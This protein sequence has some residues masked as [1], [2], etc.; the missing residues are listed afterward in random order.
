MRRRAARVASIALLA[1]L[2]V[3]GMA[4]ADG[5]FTLTGS[6]TTGRSY[7]QT[8]TSLSDCK[9]LVTGGTSGFGFLSSAELYDPA[10]GVFTATGSMIT[11][12]TEQTATLLP[13]GKVLVTGGFDG[14]GY[15]S[16]AELYDPASGAF[17][18]TGS[19]TT[20]RQ[21]QTATLLPGGKVLITGGYDA[22]GYLSSA[23]LYDPASGTFAATGSMSA[24]RAAQ[25]AT[26]LPSGKVLISGG[27]NGTG[28]L[29]SAELYDPASGTFTATGSMTS[30]RYAHSATLLPGG[31]VLV[32]GGGDNSGY[33]SSAELYD[34]ASGT[35]TAT[36]SMATRRLSPTATLLPDGKVLVTG[37]FDGGGVLSSADLYDPAA[38]TFTATGS[39]TTS[40]YRQSATLLPGGKVLITGGSDGSGV[41]SSAE[42]FTRPPPAAPVLSG[43]PASRTKST[44]AS[45]GFSGKSGASFTCSVDGGAYG[46]CGDSP[47]SLTGLA[48]GAHS[49]SVKQTDL[50]GNTSAAATASW[51]VDLTAPAAPVLSGVPSSPTS[52]TGASVS[53]TG[54]VGAT[55]QCSVDA[56]NYS[57]CTSP[58]A[59]SGLADGSHSLSVKQTD[60]AGNTG[61]IATARWSVLPASP[62][63]SSSPAALVKSTSAVFAFSGLLNASFACS[64]D[65]S[66]FFPCS[67]G[68]SF[69]GFSE[70]QH[71]FRVRQTS[72]ISGLTSEVRTFSWTVDTTAPAAPSI[73]AKPSALVNSMIASFSFTGESGASFSCSVDGGAFYPCSSP[74][75]HFVLANVSHS[76]SVKQ[77]D[78]VGNTG[79][80]S[81]PVSWFV[82]TVPPPLPVFLSGVAPAFV[83]G[84]TGSAT[85]KT[86]AYLAFNAPT[87]LTVT[88]SVDA[89]AATSCTSPVRLSGLSEGWHTLDLIHADS[90]GNKSTSRARWLVD[91]T[92]PVIAGLVVSANS[93]VIYAR[94]EIS[95]DPS[96]IAKGEL[97]T[98]VTTPSNTSIPVGA[99]AIAYP[100]QL[101]LLVRPR[102]W[103][104]VQDRAGNWSNWVK[105]R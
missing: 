95:Y 50:S 16:S 26:L 35:F 69:S 4:V 28:S 61:S 55:L 37:G 38:G 76:F 23:E 101:Q 92:S 51:T 80:A 46:A 73:T 93:S 8:A 65:N 10:S 49:L 31:N 30:G 52:S 15:V 64:L 24:T 74:W 3:P 17:T 90:A 57:S 22:A 97:S 83:S 78:S 12:R 32:T 43:Q 54:E 66:S 20:K 25:T 84:V 9:V 96:G 6:M 102:F 103:L 72:A 7:G 71:R 2:A 5:G 39:M 91:T 62:D 88:C 70:G 87:V 58:K 14:T 34:P 60:A 56:G 99:F 1:L 77:T 36:G 89:K 68:K 75:K 27:H 41:L 11:S 21:S 100:Y 45:I 98:S 42:L 86:S 18:A 79:P 63:L 67:S 33:L 82:D 13:S 85:N 104:R 81:T 94:P 48:E 47:K 44:S 105:V 53:F 19:M 29:S 40:R 59:L